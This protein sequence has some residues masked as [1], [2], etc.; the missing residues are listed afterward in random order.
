MHQQALAAISQGYLTMCK[1]IDL[2]LIATF[3]FAAS[4]SAQGAAALVDPKSAA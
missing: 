1:I 2:A 3:A 4:T